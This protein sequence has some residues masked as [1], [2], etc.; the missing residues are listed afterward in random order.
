M[1]LTNAIRYLIKQSFFSI[2]FFFSLLLLLLL[3]LLFS[4]VEDRLFVFGDANV[5]VVD[6]NVVSLTYVCMAKAAARYNLNIYDLRIF[7]F[8]V[9]S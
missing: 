4:S 2:F 9:S 3:S 7:I 1:E 5:D 6:S 8:C